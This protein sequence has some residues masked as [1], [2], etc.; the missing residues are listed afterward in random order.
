M[1]KLLKKQYEQVKELKQKIA[2][3]KAY[4][5]LIHRRN[6]DEL[7]SAALKDLGRMLE[8]FML[9]T[10]NAEIIAGDMVTYSRNL[11]IELDKLFSIYEQHLLYD[12]CIEYG[13]TLSD[14]QKLHYYHQQEKEREHH[15]YNNEF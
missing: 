9:L 2:D 12:N 1:N 5:A 7:L 10:G 4:I 15:Y 11:E 3:K 8:L 14:E 6:W 13:D